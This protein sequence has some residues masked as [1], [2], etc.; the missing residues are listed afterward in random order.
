MDG[1]AKLEPAPVVCDRDELMFRAGRASVRT[2][3]YWPAAVLMLCGVNV[4][5]LLWP[6]SEAAQLLE[7]VP[8][9]VPAVA[10][11]T[12]VDPHSYIAIARR[13]WETEPVVGPNLSGSRSRPL[14]VRSRDFE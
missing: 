11:P 13:D 4:A 10:V 6:R 1:L 2:P 3:R 8:A 9:A 12:P 7:V 14:T 5:V